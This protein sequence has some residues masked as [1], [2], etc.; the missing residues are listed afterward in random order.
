MFGALLF[1]SEGKGGV[2]IIRLATADY[3]DRMCKITDQAKA[4]L[5]AMGVDQ[6]QKGYPS[7][8]TWEQDIKESCTYLALDEATDNVMGIFAYFTTN[9]VTYNTIDGSW[10]TG[11]QFGDHAYVSLHR[12]C[13]SNVYKG[14]GVVGKMFEHVF[15]RA[16]IEGL[17]SVRIDTHP[18]NRPM[19]RALDKA[20]FVR[21]GIIY[22]QGGLEKGELRVAFEKVL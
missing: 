1:R 15:E 22:L 11:D 12:V 3:L 13:V 18:D 6:W 5:K 8:Q 10:L 9:E 19:L 7:R 21:C 17:P 4:Q 2:M 16:R 14:Q 20:G